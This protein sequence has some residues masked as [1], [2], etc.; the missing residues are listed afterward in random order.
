MKG[1]VMK[2]VIHKLDCLVQ[3]WASHQR[4][5]VSGQF[6]CVAHHIIGRANQYLRFDKDNLF[7][8]TPQEHDLIHRGIIKVE[9]YISPKRLGRIQDKR[10]E[11]LRFK[12]TSEYYENQ[13][14]IW[15]NTL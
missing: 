14:K 3:E 4:S 6:G 15:K 1:L 5:E 11:S 13:V 2:S 8:C 7:I 12:P 9:S 10:I